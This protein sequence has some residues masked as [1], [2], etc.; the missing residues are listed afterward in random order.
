[1]SNANSFNPP[2]QLPEYDLFI[3]SDSKYAINSILRIYNGPKNRVLIGNIRE[4]YEFLQRSLSPCSSIVLE[5]PNLAGEVSD[6]EILP[7]RSVR[8]RSIRLEHVKGHSGHR[9][10]DRA[11]QLAMLAA[12]NLNTNIS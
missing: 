5:L 11:D 9:W 12:Q 10:N 4:K 6:P 7:R 1:L 2:E 3:H 8:I